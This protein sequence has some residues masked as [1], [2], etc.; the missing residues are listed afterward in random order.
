MSQP[1]NTEPVLVC[2]GACKSWSRHSFVISRPVL[3]GPNNLVSKVEQIFSCDRCGEERIF[4]V[5][6]GEHYYSERPR[7]GAST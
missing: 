7:G 3:S 2:V 6:G 1:A 4:G 5:E